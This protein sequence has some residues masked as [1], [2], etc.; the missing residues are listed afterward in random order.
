MRSLK[1]GVPHAAGLYTLLSARHR[2]FFCCCVIVTFFKLRFHTPHVY[3][4]HDM[5]LARPTPVHEAMRA[6]SETRN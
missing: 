2:K 5:T 4:H 3:L 6:A 1:A